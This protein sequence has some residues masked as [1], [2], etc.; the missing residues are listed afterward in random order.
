MLK[1]SAVFGDVNRATARVLAAHGFEV[2]TAYDGCCGALALHAG[3]RQEGRALARRAN[4]PVAEN[5]QDGAKPVREGEELD[6]AR[7][8]PYLRGHF[9]D[10]PVM[11]GVLVIEAMAQVSALLAYVTEAE[12]VAQRIA[13]NR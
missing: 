12:V 13:C 7:L 10:Y 11:P 2:V 9:P 5:L 4:L 6:L 8:E 3:R 1:Q